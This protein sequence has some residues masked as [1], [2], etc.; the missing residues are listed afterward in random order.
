MAVIT[1]LA[2]SFTFFF[3]KV[4]VS[5]RILFIMLVDPETA[6]YDIRCSAP[7]YA[8]VMV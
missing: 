3:F 1:A 2:C 7:E 5:F 8:T 4:Y 6:E